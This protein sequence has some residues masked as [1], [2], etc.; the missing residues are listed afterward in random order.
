MILVFVNVHILNTVVTLDENNQFCAY[1]L[2]ACHTNSQF[3]CKNG[4]CDN[5]GQEILEEQKNPST[6]ET[7]L[8]LIN[9]YVYI[10][11]HG[12]QASKCKDKITP[13]IQIIN[14][15]TINRSEFED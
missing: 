2:T 13:N 12:E 8:K 5:S 1:E 14:L 10:K 4:V 9:M 11:Q 3:R 6:K 7:S 15:E